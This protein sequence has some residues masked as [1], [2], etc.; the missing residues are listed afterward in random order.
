MRLRLRDA[1]GPWI[2]SSSTRR[3]TPV[4]S[5]ANST[6]PSRRTYAKHAYGSREV[7]EWRLR[8]ALGAWGER[9]EAEFEFVD[10]DRFRTP[11]SRTGRRGARRCAWS[12]SIGRCAAPTIC[13]SRTANPQVAPGTRRRQ[14]Q[15]S[16]GAEQAS[17]HHRPRACPPDAVTEA[18]LEMVRT[19]RA[20]AFGDLEPFN[21]AVRRRKQRPASITSS[22]PPALVWVVEDAMATD[23]DF[24]FHSVISMYINIGLLDP[25]LLPPRRRGAGATATRPSTPWKDSSA[26]SSAGASSSAAF[27]GCTCRATP[28]RTCSRPT[29]HCR[30]STGP[31]TRRCAASPKPSAPRASTPT[32]TTSSASWS[33]ATSRSSPASARARANWYLGRV[34]RR[35]RV[36]GTACRGR[37]GALCRRRGVRVQALRGERQVHRPHVDYCKGCRYDVKASSGEDACPLNYLYW[38]FVARNEE[39]APRQS[40]HGHDLSQSRQAGPGARP[41]MRADAARARA[42]LDAL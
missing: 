28:T 41:A 42:D 24:V 4:H 20:D 36:G 31:V 38:D 14:S 37:H 30:R 3:T 7:D 17:A 13:C 12:S 10:D 6:A 29:V 23:E 9:A 18:V 26:R 32:R 40:A 16:A 2:T 11:S 35:L 5:P 15:A 34:R 39:T 27:T 22:R 21:F 19:Q 8:D 33:P 1:A 25:H